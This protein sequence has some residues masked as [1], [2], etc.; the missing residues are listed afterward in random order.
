MI[1]NQ[2]PFYGESGGQLG[3]VGTISWDKGSA[4]VTDTQKTPS[5]LFIH[6][7]EIDRWHACQGARGSV[8]D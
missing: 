6:H 4:R 3:D 2:T 1:V 7:V 8:A 5:G